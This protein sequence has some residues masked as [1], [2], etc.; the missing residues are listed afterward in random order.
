MIAVIS[1]KL[2]YLAW[3]YTRGIRDVILFW[4]NMLWFIGN[5]FSMSIL[6]RNLFS[7]WKALEDK[8]TTTAFVLSDVLSVFLINLIMRIVGFLIRIVFLVIGLVFY[9]LMSVAGPILIVLWLL[10]PFI[11]V[12]SFIAGIALIVS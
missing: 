5:F 6:L 8:R 9:I 4:Q 1:L 12:G 11:M 10:L 2:Q 3:H 7:P